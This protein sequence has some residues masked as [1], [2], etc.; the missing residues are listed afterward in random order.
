VRYNGASLLGLAGIVVKSHGSADAT[1]FHYAVQR[2]VQEVS[3]DL[4]RH[5]AAEL[6]PRRPAISTAAVESTA[7]LESSRREA[8]VT[9]KANKSIGD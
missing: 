3:R 9:M 6:V 5:L 8:P 7:D 4:P 2:A 1:G